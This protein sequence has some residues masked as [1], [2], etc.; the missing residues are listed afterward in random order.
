MMLQDK[1]SKSLRDHTA[2][3]EETFL[4]QANELVT[5]A[6]QVAEIF[7]RGGRLMVVG[8]GPL[9]SIANLVA[10]LFRYRLNIERPALPALS[11]CQDMPLAASLAK[12]GRSGA[13]FAQQ[14]QLIA[15]EGDAVLALGD[16]SHNE[17]ILDG[18]AE[19]RERGCITAALLPE[20]EEINGD[21]PHFLFRLSTDSV[22]RAAET[23][24][25]FG[26]LL[27]ELVE[28]ELFGI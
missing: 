19:A 4:M 3:L 8:S 18:L 17:A 23:G 15:N 14:L 16:V 22:G 11:L 24:L 13:F 10:N 12:D 2:V 21:G 25:F 6:S 26:H 1:I 27:C 7:N 28:G 20:K 9:C 5:F